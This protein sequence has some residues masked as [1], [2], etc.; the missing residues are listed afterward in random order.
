MGYKI[1]EF[2]EMAL[3]PMRLILV[4]LRLYVLINEIQ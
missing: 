4:I 1:K 2:N 3:I